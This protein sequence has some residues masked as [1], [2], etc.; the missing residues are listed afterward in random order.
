MFRFSLFF[1]FFFFPGFWGAVF[2]KVVMVFMF[3]QITK[4]N[5]NDLIKIIFE[6]FFV[7]KKCVE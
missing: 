2:V 7:C 4:I 1:F 5:A 3:F 6:R